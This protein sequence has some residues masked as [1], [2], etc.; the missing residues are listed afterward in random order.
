MF[1]CY[2]VFLA[3]SPLK[4]FISSRTSVYFCHHSNYI[5]PISVV[6]A[7]SSHH[8]MYVVSTSTIISGC[9]TDCNSITQSFQSLNTFRSNW[10]IIISR[11]LVYFSLCKLTAYCGNL[12]IHVTNWEGSLL[13]IYSISTECIT[14]ADLEQSLNGKLFIIHYF[15]LLLVWVLPKQ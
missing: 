1:G 4:H 3:G 6:T 13:V 5:K 11:V 15:W 8:H 10:K 7:Q 9:H 2:C 14:A 12:I